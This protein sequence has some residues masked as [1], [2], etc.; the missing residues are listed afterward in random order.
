M[1]NSWTPFDAA[2]IVDPEGDLDVRA[3]DLQTVFKHLGVVCNHNRATFDFVLRW[4][5]QMF[6]YPHVKVTVM[7]VIAGNKGAGKGAF[8]QL[9]KNM[10]GKA[11]VLSTEEPGKDVW[12][13][14]NGQM[15]NAFLVWLDDVEK[16]DFAKDIK[17]VKRLVTERTVQ[18]EKKHV[19]AVELESF[20]R[21]VVSANDLTIAELLCGVDE[22]RYAYWEASDEL[23]AKT[24]A[25]VAYHNAF[26]A[27]IEKP[28]LQHDF[29]HFLMS[30]AISI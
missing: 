2:K 19:N 5:A 24:Q 14:F 10:M 27:L 7:V 26:A 16:A 25:N 22:R 23:C 18:V 30:L 29:Y 17:H 8:V 12:G 4:L 20:H 21:F 9:I 3:D 13:K 15:M 1:Y 28:Q 6:K 11:K